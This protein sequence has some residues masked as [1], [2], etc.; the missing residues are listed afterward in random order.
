MALTPKQQRFVA[1]Y[2]IDANATQAAIRAGYSERTAYA[3][4]HENLNKPEIIAAI[5]A[6]EE[7]R[8]EKLEITAVNLLTDVVDIRRLAKSDGVYTAALKANDMLGKSLRDAN[9]FAEPATKHQMVD[10]NDQP[11]PASELAR[12]VAF[13]LASGMAVMQALPDPPARCR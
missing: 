1:E 6:S 8:L 4:G 5:K 7:K 11:I 12:H 2:Q 3:I 9:P 13:L 10:E